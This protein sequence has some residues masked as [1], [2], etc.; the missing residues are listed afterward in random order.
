[1][2]LAVV[3]LHSPLDLLVSGPALHIAPECTLVRASQTMRSCGV[4]AVL[5]G[6]GPEAIVT[7]HDLARAIAEGLSMDSPVSTVVT[8]DPVV[9]S[10]D[11]EILDAATVMLNRQ[12]RHLVVELRSGRWA[13]LPLDVVAAVLLQ[14]ARPDFWLSDL[15]VKV[16]MT[17]LPTWPG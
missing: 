8:Q 4:S 3:H 14:A 7:E 17:E 15:R 16:E 6:H 13:I 2:T 1:M 11:A 5:V 10:A 9:L 12:L